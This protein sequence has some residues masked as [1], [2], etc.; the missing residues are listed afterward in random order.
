[1]AIENRLKRDYQYTLDR[2]VEGNHIEDF[3][4][5]TRAG[6]CE[7]FASAMVML[8]RSLGIPSRVV[9]G[10]YCAEWNQ[11]ANAFTVRQSDAHSWVEA[12]F[13]RYGWMTFEPT[14]AAG[15]GRAAPLSPL[16]LAYGQVMDALKVRWYRYVIDYNFRDQ[17]VMIRSVVRLQAAVSRFFDRLAFGQNGF[18]AAQ[19]YDGTTVFGLALVLIMCAVG[20]LGGFFLLQALLRRLGQTRRAGPKRSRML[21]RFYAEICDLLRRRGLVREPH[22][23]PGEFAVRVSEQPGLEPM[24]QVTDWYYRERYG[25]VPP[26]PAEREK[27]K[28]FKETLRRGDR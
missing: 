26:S 6:H 27:I 21:V 25:E 24:Q 7:Y 17:L 14:P 3:L 8:L 18:D 13:D 11:I 5:R 12:Y 2:P 9:N 22:E 1:M 20:A 16:M 23:T 10:Y 19:G 4:F 28:H 15:I